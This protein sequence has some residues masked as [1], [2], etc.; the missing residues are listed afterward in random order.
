MSFPDALQNFGIVF[1][2]LLRLLAVLD[3][4]SQVRE[5]RSD[6]LASQRLRRAKCVVQCLAGH[7]PRHCVAHKR[8]MCG[9]VAKPSILRRSQQQGSHQTHSF[10][11][12]LFAADSTFLAFLH[13]ALISLPG[14]SGVLLAFSSYQEIARVR[15]SRPANTPPISRPLTEI[16]PRP[17]SLPPFPTIVTIAF[18]LRR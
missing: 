1:R 9:V 16:V 10:L 18:H 14:F 13:S 6:L 7:K 17:Q 15:K 3:V 11:P 5:D 8:I 2:N 12:L 4:F